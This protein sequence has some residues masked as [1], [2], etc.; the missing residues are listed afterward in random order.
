[1]QHK[2]IGEF[3]SA[4]IDGNLDVVQQSFSNF[5]MQS[6]IYN[7]GLNFA[8]I[9]NRYDVVKFLLQQPKVDPTYRE[10]IAFRKAALN[11]WLDIMTEL[12]KNPDVNPLDGEC[13]SVYM[14]AQRDKLDVI[15]LILADSRF[16]KMND[17]DIRLRQ[18]IFD[19]AFSNNSQKTV[20]WLLSITQ[21]DPL[22]PYIQFIPTLLDKKDYYAFLAFQTLNGRFQNK[23]VNL[24]MRD[25]YKLLIQLKKIF[26]H[27]IIQYILSLVI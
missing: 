11:E 25:Y 17:V 27:D 15:K 3:W 7:K 5:N 14:A 4:C 19:I 13:E 16:S 22:I 21:V 8:S 1:M 9:Y 18:F 20:L 24:F 26:K 6:I 12:L 2:Y 23:E 10:N